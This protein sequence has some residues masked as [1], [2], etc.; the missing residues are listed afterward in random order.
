[1]TYKRVVLLLVLVCLPCAMAYTP[2]NWLP[3]H[4]ED[5]AAD[6]D[7][8]AVVRVVGLRLA[9]QAIIKEQGVD[10]VWHDAIFRGYVADMVILRCIKADADPHIRYQAGSTITLGVG[11][12]MS[13]RSADPLRIDPASPALTMHNSHRGYDLRIGQTYLMFL[14]KSTDGP[15]PFTPRSGPHSIY[16]LQPGDV[17]RRNTLSGYGE[18]QTG[19]QAML[20]KLSAQHAPPEHLHGGTGPKEDGQ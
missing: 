5:D 3:G 18:E 6:S 10:D 16:W 15:D 2:A 12:D 9:G 11:G 13:G 4:A 20:E 19:W 17:Y 1:M 14:D 7:M 8:I